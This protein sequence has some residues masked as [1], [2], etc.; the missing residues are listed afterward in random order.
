[1][2]KW[3]ISEFGWNKLKGVYAVCSIINGKNIVYYIGSSKNIGKRLSNPKHPYRKLY[4]KGVFVYIKYKQTENYIQL[5]KELI[6][7]INPPLNN[8]HNG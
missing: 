2:Q 4:S 6:S 8:Q 1:M 3:S 5:E 7:K